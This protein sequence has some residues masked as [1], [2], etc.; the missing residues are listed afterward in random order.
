M[1]SPTN[2]GVPKMFLNSFPAL[3]WWAIPKSISL[4]LGLGTFLSSSMMFSGWEIKKSD[5]NKQ[6]R[7]NEHLILLIQRTQKT[8]TLLVTHDWPWGQSERCVWSADSERHLESASET[9]WP[10]PPSVTP[11]RRGSRTTPLR[12]P[13]PG[14]G[15]RQSCFQR[16]RARWWCCCAESL[17]GCSLHA[18]SPRGSPPVGWRRA[19][20]FWWTWLRIPRPCSSPCTYGQLQTA[21]FGRRKQ[22]THKFNVSHTVEI[23]TWVKSDSITWVRAFLFWSSQ[24]LGS[25]SSKH[26][27]L[28]DLMQVRGKPFREQ[29]VLTFTIRIPFGLNC[30][31]PRTH[32]HTQSSF[33]DFTPQQN[34]KGTF[35]SSNVRCLLHYCRGKAAHIQ[36]AGCVS[37]EAI[38]VKDQWIKNF[39]HAAGIYKWHFGL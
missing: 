25:V 19:V 1:I 12:T 15:S 6:D 37:L 22:R 10:P 7:E 32:S 29:N 30:P 33:K 34:K 17:A 24:I 27:S 2:S 8:K 9:A 26:H 31:L 21:H 39:Y 35:K 18:Q 38:R 23:C 28:F 20:A 5:I 3:I 36:K 14:S 13:V 4:I 11:S 16:C